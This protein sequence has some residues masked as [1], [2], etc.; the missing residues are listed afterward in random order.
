MDYSKILHD[1]MNMFTKYK[2]LTFY[3]IIL[4]FL[5]FFIGSLIYVY[6]TIWAYY[7]Y[8]SQH[9]ITQKEILSFFEMIGNNITN[10][11]YVVLIIGILFFLYTFIPPLLV[12][13]VIGSIGRI[14]NNQPNNIFISISIGLKNYLKLLEFDIITSVISLPKLLFLTYAIYRFLGPNFSGFVLFILIFFI[15]LVFFFSIITAYVPYFIVLKNETVLSAFTKSVHLVIMYFKDVFLIFSISI[16]IM[17]RVLIN[18]ILFLLVPMGITMMFVYFMSLFGFWISFIISFIIG[19][20]VLILL[21]WISARFLIFTY[22]F[23][24]ITFFELEK[25][26]E[27]YKLL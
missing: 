25:K 21:I 27:E 16:I 18:I 7:M 17:L 13:S 3:G 8:G 10:T 11:L 19:I 20:L 22:A 5:D 14:L 1:A 4:G 24:T 9:K 15:I 23:W 26:E 12:G 2:Y 6:E